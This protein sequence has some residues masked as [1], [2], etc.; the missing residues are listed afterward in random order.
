MKKMVSDCTYI[1]KE[2]ISI[3]G[4]FMNVTISFFSWQQYGNPMPLPFFPQKKFTLF[5]SAT[6]RHIIE[7]IQKANGIK[8][9]VRIT[10][11]NL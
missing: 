9:S 6:A 8:K 5:T 1:M 2:V 3:Y 10:G 11:Q 7:S 4:N